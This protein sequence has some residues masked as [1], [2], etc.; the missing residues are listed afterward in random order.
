[1]RRLWPNTIAKKTQVTIERT[2]EALL[3]FV[4]DLDEEDSR[5]IREGLDEE[6]STIFHFIE[7][8]Y[9]RPSEITRIKKVAVGLLAKLKAEKL[10]IDHWRDK[11]ST[12]DAVRIAISDSCG[13]TTLVCR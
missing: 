1:M 3:R 9:L 4:N 8:Q 5:T 11:K 13:A 6:S 10:R 12:R 7:K 2:L